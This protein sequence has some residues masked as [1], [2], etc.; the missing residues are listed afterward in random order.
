MSGNSH[1]AIG[2]ML[3]TVALKI[4]FDESIE[5]E[6]F[7]T[8]VAVSGIGSL[9]PDIDHAG[10]KL[11]SRVPLIAKMF[12]HRGFTHTIWALVLFT[13]L[14]KAL[15][16]RYMGLSNIMVIIF[17]LSYLGH[18]LADILT[19]EGLKP[20]KI[21]YEILNIHVCIPII[22]NVLIEKM[23]VYALCIVTIT[24]MVT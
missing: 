4:G 22:R 12:K 17:A 18:I 16:D 8:A 15:N 5:L 21:G 1:I 7:G 23:F 3:S 9:F 19:P 6:S 10:S 24:L 20:L 14:F 11:G 13:L 2:I